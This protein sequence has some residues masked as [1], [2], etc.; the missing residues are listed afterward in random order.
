MSLKTLLLFV[1]IALA[2]CNSVHSNANVQTNNAN[3]PTTPTPAHSAQAGDEVKRVT[4]AELDQLMKDG[5][6]IV[7]DVRS[8]A[9][10]DAGHI[11]G[12][13]LIPLPDV[14]TRA[15]ELPKDKMIVTYCS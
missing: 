15:N 1:A 14:A 3:S 12:A 10:W 4:T 9:M 2:A 8:Q 11:K 7:V 13:K 6:A 5:K